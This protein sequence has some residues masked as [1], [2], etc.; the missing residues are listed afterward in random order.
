MLENEIIH[1]HYIGVMFI[2]CAHCGAKHF[3]SERVANKG[4]SFND[5]CNHSEGHCYG[6]ST[7]LCTKDVPQTVGLLSL[8]QCRM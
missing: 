2:V 7:A 6:V 8:L 3:A 1:E 4:D 5:C